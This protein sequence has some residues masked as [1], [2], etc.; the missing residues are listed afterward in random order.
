VKPIWLIDAGPLIALIRQDDRDHR[1]CVRALASLPSPVAT[2]WPV[3]TEAVHVVETPR[4]KDAIFEMLERRSL[5]LLPLDAGDIPRIRSL[6]HKY[7]T[8]PMDLA[9]ATLVRVA[10]RDGLNRIFTLDTDFRVY[11]L[12]RDRPFTIVP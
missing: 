8:Q 3:V 6:I 12:G 2:T 5:Q 10:E 11:R 1:V 7:R 9:D 4:G